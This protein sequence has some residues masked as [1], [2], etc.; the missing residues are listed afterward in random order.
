VNRHYGLSKAFIATFVSAFKDV[1]VLIMTGQRKEHRK[2]AF[3]VWK[4]FPA[5]NFQQSK[6][7]QI[8]AHNTIFHLLNKVKSC[9][10]TGS[11]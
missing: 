11:V 1:A 8:E 10:H 5:K 9:T 3:L 2:Q 6:A 4:F 7:S